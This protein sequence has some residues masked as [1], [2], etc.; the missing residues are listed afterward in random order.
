[1]YCKQDK[2][3]IDF[4]KSPITQPRAAVGDEIVW[5]LEQ[6]FVFTSASVLLFLKW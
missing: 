3:P 1:M 2:L 6:T 4:D 5:A